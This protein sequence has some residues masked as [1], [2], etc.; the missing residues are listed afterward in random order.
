MPP[1]PIIL[2]G[3]VASGVRNAVDNAN[4]TSAANVAHDTRQQAEAIA[5]DVEMLF[6]ITEVLWHIVKQQNNLTDEMLS[7]WVDEIDARDGIIN[8]RRPKEQ[9]PDCANCGRKTIAGNKKCL[10]CGT[11]IKLDLFKKY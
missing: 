8:G 1:D 4:K 2:G 10:Y 3:I 9:R 6:M 5:L 11:A 7:D